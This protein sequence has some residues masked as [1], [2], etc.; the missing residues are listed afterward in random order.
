MLNASKRE[1]A[2][3]RS[4]AVEFDRSVLW[5]KVYEEE[6]GTAGGSPFGLLIA[7]YQF[8]QHPDDVSLLTG[9]SEVS[10]ASFARSWRLLRPICWASIPMLISMS[11]WISKRF[12]HPQ[13]L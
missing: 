13:L 7:D 1:L 12:S 8:S 5:R 3:D 6:F 2:R 11:F 10:A 9:L 4:S